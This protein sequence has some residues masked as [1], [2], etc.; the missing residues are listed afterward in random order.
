MFER[1][2]TKLVWK[3]FRVC[4]TL[5]LFLDKRSIREAWYDYERDTYYARV[6]YGNPQEARPTLRPRKLHFAL[7]YLVGLLTALRCDLTDHDIENTGYGNPDSGE[8][9][10]YCKRCGW[11]YHHQLY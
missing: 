2:K 8:M 5:G 10:G 1:L 4:E 3:F 7:D 6:G 11:S 9:S